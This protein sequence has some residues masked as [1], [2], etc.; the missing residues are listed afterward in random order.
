[1]V[2]CSTNYPLRKS[3][4]K[5]LGFGVQCAR[6]NAAIV[7][8]YRPMKPGTNLSIDPRMK[9]TS[10]NGHAVPNV[11]QSD[12]KLELFG[13]D[14]LVNILGLKRYDHSFCRFCLCNVDI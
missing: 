13:F 9:M 5:L 4:S 2:F 3:K 14:S 6:T 10:S 8:Y 12:S 7:L 11:S 1:V